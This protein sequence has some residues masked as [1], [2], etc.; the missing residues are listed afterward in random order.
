KRMPPFFDI[1]MRGFRDRAEVAEVAAVLGQRLRPLPPET[2][3]V[4]EAVGRVLAQDVISA[5]AVP[6]FDRAAMDGYALRA[7]ETFG[8]GSYSPAEFQIAGEALPARPFAGKLRAG[9]AVRIMTGAPLPDGADAVLQA[10]AAEESDGR[11]RV[12]DAVPPGRNVGRR[13]EDIEK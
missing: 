3:P 13:G 9:Q 8:A 11:L 4:P 1:R 10:E 12:S 7:P 6:A 5:V 2:V